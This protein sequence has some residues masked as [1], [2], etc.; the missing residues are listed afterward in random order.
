MSQRVHVSSANDGNT[1]AVGWMDV[2]LS[3]E[4]VTGVVFQY[5]SGYVASRSAFAISP[6]LPLS[7]HPL[8]L[9]T[10]PGAVRDAAPDAW[11]RKLIR[12]HLPGRVM[13]ELDA[14]LG[15]SDSGRMG[16]LRFRIEPGGEFVKA[17]EPI[18]AMLKLE[19]LRRAAA[20][21]ERDDDES[22]SLMLLAAGSA[23]LGGARPKA[24][25]SDGERELL[26]K[27]RST[28]DE[29]DVI[30]WEAVTLELARLAGI[31]VPEFKLI[32]SG[33]ETV[34]LLE[35]FDRREGNRVPYWSAATVIG[36]EEGDYLDLAEAIQQGET[37]GIKRQLRELWR[38]AVFNVAVHN[39]D[40]HFRNHGFLYGEHGWVLSAAFDIN[41]DIVEGRARATPICGASH[42]VHE[43]SALVELAEEL[44]IGP[45]EWQ[46]I[47]REVLDAVDAWPRVS[48]A[49]QVD[50]AEAAR[51]WR[52][53]AGSTRSRLSDLLPS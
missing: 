45:Q 3:G 13:T 38:R 29:H 50:E 15:A 6:D 9:T 7:V 42:P 28:Q 33:A 11:G 31:T 49:Y 51:F 4:Q 16:A 19:D 44:G 37:V 34:L 21:V 39:T 24:I 12:R 1:V 35:R 14:L 10:L 20:S 43:S 22:S 40:D 46:P 41:P 32:D 25:V 30:R 5:D 27:F 8:P 17:G 48:A 53:L 2:V 52:V 47:L 23:S 26:A 18:P 36:R